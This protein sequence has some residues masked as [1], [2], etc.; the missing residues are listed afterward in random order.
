MIRN[1]QYR[2]FSA[3]AIKP[4]GWLKKQLMLQANGLAGNLDKI[5]PDI[6]DSM[7]I[8][9]SRYDWERVPYWLD[10]FIPLAYLLDNADMKKRAQTYVY[11]I[12]DR[13][14]DDGWL[15]PCRPEHRRHYDT[16]AALLLCKVLAAYCDVTGDERVENALYRGLKQ[17]SDHINGATLHDW[18]AARWFEGL[19]PIFWLYEKRPESWLILLAKK[20]N[21]QGFDWERVFATDMLHN[22]TDGWDY[23]S[24]VVNLGMMLKSRALMSR[25]TGEDPDTFAQKAYAWLH[26]H[27]GMACGHFTGDENLSGTSPIQGSELCSVNEAMFSFE[28]LFQISGNPYWL[29]LLEK[30]AFNALPATVSPDMWT[31]QYVQM[32]NQVECSRTPHRVFRTNNEEA[33]IFGLE[34]HFG[35]CTANMGQGFPKFALSALYKTPNGIACGIPLPMT[36]ETD[37]NGVAVTCQTITDYPF[38]GEVRFVF[39]AASPVSFD[40]TLRIP[41]HASFALLNGKEAPSGEMVTLPISVKEPVEVIL[42]LR[43]ATRFEKRPS[44]MLALWRGP[45]LYSLPI[46]ERWEMREYEQGGVARKFPYCDYYIYPESDFNYGFATADIE[47]IAVCEKDFDAPFTPKQPPIELQISMAKVAWEKPD[48]RCALLPVSNQAISEPEIVTLIPYGCTN[49]RMSEMPL[50]EK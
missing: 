5:W 47:K 36:L 33:H 16:W 19:I 14:Q 21:V 22:L 24:H 9:G 31:H 25:I 48:G 3:N 10:G 38:R 1:L 43:F 41:S 8:G 13:Q 26:T 39:S 4:E 2:P 6:K 44:G 32:T 30:E 42:S 34:P 50:V 17:F 27:H 15:C 12:V 28:T 37:I 35:C 20:L 46:A 18:G 23:I 11:G 49:L 29:D 40:F 7:W 45:L